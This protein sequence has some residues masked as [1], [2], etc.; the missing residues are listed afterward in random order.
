MRSR[1]EQREL[2][3]VKFEKCLLFFFVTF[4]FSSPLLFP[5]FHLKSW[6]AITAAVSSVR[7]RIR[8]LIYIFISLHRIGGTIV[9]IKLCC[10]P[11][12]CPDTTNMFHT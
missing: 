12:I 11:Q 4:H 2:P 5:F 1:W 9:D 3:E 8:P 10:K 6:E 7:A